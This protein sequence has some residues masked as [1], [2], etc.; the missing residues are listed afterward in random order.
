MGRLA[1][2]DRE[3]LAPLM[4]RH[5]Q[6]LHRI[7][8]AYLR[9]ADEA[10]DVVQE[11][12]VK[13]FT[14]AGSWQEQAEVGPWLTRIAVN[15]AIDRYRRGKRRWL[16]EEPLEQDGQGPTFEVD[17]PSPERR[18]LGRELADRIGVA[19]RSLPERQRAVFVLRHYEEMSLEEIGQ[20]LGLKIGTVKSTLHRAVHHLRERLAGV[21]A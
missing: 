14:H 4:E 10:L 13:A 8:L 9:D 1:R 16:A 18:V 19:V 2:G 3:A 21:R 5:Y 12:F 15:K 17:D 6:R 7:V 11:T 20:T